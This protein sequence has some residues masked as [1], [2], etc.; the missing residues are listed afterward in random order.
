MLAHPHL[1]ALSPDDIGA[2]LSVYL[3]IYRSFY[4]SMYLAI[5]TLYSSIYLFGSFCCRFIYLLSMYIQ[6]YVTYVAYMRT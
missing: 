5:L 3:S 6:T 2:I 4:L 1:E